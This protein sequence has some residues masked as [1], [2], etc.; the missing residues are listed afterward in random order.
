MDTGGRWRR[1]PGRAS[2]GRRSVASSRGLDEMHRRSK[3]G[4][5]ADG[6]ARRPGHHVSISRAITGSPLPRSSGFERGAGEAHTHPVRHTSWLYFNVETRESVFVTLSVTVSQARRYARRDRNI[7]AINT[8]NTKSEIVFP[9]SAMAGP[10]RV[11]RDSDLASTPD[12]MHI[13]PSLIRRH[14]RGAHLKLTCT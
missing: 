10:P 12:S 1:R 13:R 2:A 3:V 5:S 8:Q 6:D 14:V 7:H 11:G 9:Q 4:A